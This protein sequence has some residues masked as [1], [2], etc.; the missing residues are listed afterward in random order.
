MNLK[1]KLTKVICKINLNKLAVIFLSFFLIIVGFIIVIPRVKAI[2]PDLQ[3]I[4]SDNPDPVDAGGYLTYTLNIT[5]ID[6]EWAADEVNVTDTLPSEVTF[7]YANPS[8]NGSSN[9]TYW[10]F[11]SS[12]DPGDSEIIIIN[13]TVNIS[14]YG[15]ITNIANVTNIHEEYNLEN[16]VDSEDTNVSSPPVAVND[17][18]STP[19]DTQIDINVTSNDYDHGGYIN[20][21]TVTI[22]TD[23]L[24]GVTDVNSTTGIVTYTPDLNYNGFD[25]FS[26]TVKDNDGYTS[27]VANVSINVTEVNDPPVI[28]TEDDTDAVEDELY[29]VDYEALDDE[30]D[31]LTWSLDTNT[32][33]LSIVSDTGV[34][35][36]TPTNDDVGWYWVNVSVDDGNGGS[37]FSNF[38]LTVLNVNDPPNTPSK[39]SGLTNLKKGKSSSY[40]TN[41]TDPDISDQIRFR[42]DWG[43]GIISA[44]TDWVNSTESASK[45]KS[46][47]KGGIYNVKAQAED[48]YGTLSNWS[49][50]LVVTVT[51][52]GSGNL[53]PIANDDST[54]TNIETAVWIDVLDNDEDTD[55]TLEPSSVIVTGGPIHGNTTVNTTTG[56]VRYKPN[57]DFNESD[58]FEYTV[59]DNDG[60]ASNEATVTI[61]VGGGVKADASAGSPYFGFI[62]ENITFDG[63]L[64]YDPDPE[65]YIVSW[66]WEFGDDT[67]GTGEV[68][69]HS[70]EEAGM[71]TVILTVTDNV[72][73]TDQDKF[74]VEIIK[75]NIPPSAPIV[76]GP[77]S[78]A[79]EVVYN[80]T[81]VS[82]DA[83]NDAI[84]YIFNWGDGSNVTV[85]EFLSN[86]TTTIQ[87]HSWKVAGQYIISVYANDNKTD[88]AT[89]EYIVYID[90]TA[91]GD[92]GYLTDDDGDGIFD[93]F[94]DGISIDTD[95]GREND[96]YLIDSNGDG[97]WDYVFNIETGLST[98]INYVYL[99]YLEIYEEKKTP[100]FEFISFLVIL[101]L[102]IFILRRK[103]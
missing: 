20:V 98:Y 73:I 67:N 94:H 50:A 13:V 85:T 88:S 53:P 46:W 89:T 96:T 71:Y 83:D 76:D 42:F 64:S 72:N 39:P 84:K 32:T 31:T 51:S 47:Y 54:N 38:T 14:A 11:F 40:S 33:F 15:T 103:R 9:L 65:G 66:H 60:A 48:T 29:E 81:A 59:D 10:W 61:I 3:M 90:V 36:G 6:D 22:I 8:P 95:L 99:K 77:T 7:N 44:W 63:S 68:T 18:V 102:V 41:T 26:Y 35:S 101:A 17:S 28:T 87:N 82:T 45:I 56:E 49:T 5:N 4:K 30:G 57:V 93:M 12:I 91:V 92:I 74:T 16:N 70:Y 62:G 97:N 21:T 55:G 37:D 27:N 86:G 69:T 52:S 79:I 19:E 58:T 100:G 78:G 75:P 2:H 34:L 24:N 23:A 1:N 43:D 25:N 80:F